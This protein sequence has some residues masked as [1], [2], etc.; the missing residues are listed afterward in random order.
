MKLLSV[1]KNL[2]LDSEKVI[3]NPD[4]NFFIEFLRPYYVTTKDRQY[5]F[6]SIQPGRRPDRVF[7]MVP[8]NY[9][10]GV[11]QRNF[12]NHTGRRIYDVAMKYLKEVK[13]ILQDGIQGESGYETG[14]R[15]VMS[16]DNPHSAYMAWMGKLMI[17]P[18][19]KGMRI[20]CYNYT[21]PEGLPEHYVKEIKNFWPTYNPA[22]PLTLFDFTEMNKDVRKVL[23]LG[24]D[25]FGGAFKK[26]NLTMVWNRGEIDGMISYHGGCTEERV[27]KGLSGTGKT[28]LTVGPELEQDD[29]LLGRPIYADNGRID[30]V[31]LVGLEAASYAKSEGLSEKSPE[32]PGLM[33]STMVDKNG[34]RPVVLA[35]NIDCDGVD[36]VYR[37]MG[38]YKVKVPVKTDGKDIGSLQCTEYKKS[39]TT[40]GRFVFQ[41]S[42]LNRNWGSGR[43]KYLKTESLSFK[44]FDILEPVFRVTEPEMAVA[45]DSACESIITSAVAKQKVGTRVKSYA[46]TDFIVAEQAN[47]ALLKLKMYKDLGLGMDGKLIFF[48][49]NSG[50]IGEHDLNGNQI[51]KQDANE[52][53]VPKKDKNGKI[54]YDKNGKTIYEGQGEKIRVEDTKKL[55]SLVEKRKIEKWLE[56]PVYRYLIPSP[57]ELEEVHGMKNFGKRFNPLKYYTPQQI[58]E[59]IK[60][61]IKE[62]TVFLRDLFRGQKNEGK[63][64]DVMS[65][66]E[67]LKIPS[68]DE[69]KDFYENNYSKV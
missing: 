64:Q 6:A 30:K 44:R 67:N 38:K 53:P 60:R 69:I 39:G 28:T 41:F 29:A 12:D 33:K 21:I 11:A 51:R 58:I 35:M 45:L 52:K 56:H 32:W 4:D 65:I 49:C 36:Y 42:E 47:Q 18:P 34:E 9:R 61:D 19:K 22:E 62:R 17:F 37:D 14:L 48:I 55:I 10:L 8:E 66:W 26:P 16:V 1:D 68:P 5:L 54:M 59:F 2:S 23:N 15:I 43:V 13:V 63:L 25:Y 3:C 7:Y 50:Y 24:V 27:L 31:Q 46:A 40:N 20:S 57:E